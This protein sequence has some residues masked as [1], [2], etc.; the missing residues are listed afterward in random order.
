MSQLAELIPPLPSTLH[1]PLFFLSFPLCTQTHNTCKLGWA[2]VEE[3]FKQLIKTIKSWK[4]TLGNDCAIALLDCLGGKKESLAVV[5][6]ISQGSP[7]K[8]LNLDL[9]NY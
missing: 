1:P 9:R 2:Q 4:L 7:Y 8:L 5:L 3:P 6:L